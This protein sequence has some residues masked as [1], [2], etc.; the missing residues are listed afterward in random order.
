MLV[1]WSTTGTELKTADL[2]KLW[3]SLRHLELGELVVETLELKL[4][5]SVFLGILA[6]EARQNKAVN[7]RASS[8]LLTV[9]GRSLTNGKS[10]KNVYQ[11]YHEKVGA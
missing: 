6:L 5:G 7:Y 3:L 8:T 4:R 9:L 1:L 2:F 11:T 10:T